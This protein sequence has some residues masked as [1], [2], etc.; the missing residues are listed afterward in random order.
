MQGLYAIVS[1]LASPRLVSV[2][3]TSRTAAAQQQYT[4]ATTAAR[5]HANR[6]LQ[7]L[8]TP[9]ASGVGASCW[10]HVQGA[11]HH[12]QSTYRAASMRLQLLISLQEG[13]EKL[14]HDIQQQQQ[15]Q[16]SVIKPGVSVKSA[17]PLSAFELHLISN[18]QLLS[19]HHEALQRGCSLLQQQLQCLQAAQTFFAWAESVVAEVRKPLTVNI[20]LQQRQRQQQQPAAVLTAPSTSDM[21]PLVQQLPA[22]SSA[23]APLVLQKVVRQLEQA[24]A[25]TGIDLQQSTL[26]SG[27]D[28]QGKQLLAQYQQA[29]A[30]AMVQAG[31]TCDVPQVL[32]EVPVD[33]QRLVDR[34]RDQQQQQQTGETAQSRQ[35]SFWYRRHVDKEQMMLLTARTAQQQDGGV[36]DE[37]DAA[38]KGAFTALDINSTA[39]GLHGRSDGAAAGDTSL[40][41]S[42]S[43]ELQ[44]LGAVA[45]QVAKQLART[46]AVNKEQ[47]QVAADVLLPPE[48]GCHLYN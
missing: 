32:F 46:R 30:V 21:Q 28:P 45:T 37:S 14:L 22:A 27:S 26:P 41:V 40:A 43:A 24:A 33:I 44:R 20:D 2:Q 11:A 23:V 34:V 19:Q 35:Q 6:V 3:D 1:A 47:L 16:P 5:Q 15:T 31:V 9:P 12:L 18:P 39:A 8:Q 13:R 42:M 17:Y 25:Q 38:L 36:E 10:Q 29:A 48:H 7:T 4:A